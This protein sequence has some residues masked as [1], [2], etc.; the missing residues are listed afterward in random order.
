MRTVWNCTKLS[1]GVKAWPAVTCNALLPMSHLHHAVPTPL[2]T[3]IAKCHVAETTAGGWC[4]GWQHGRFSI[5]RF[6][7]DLSAHAVSILRRTTPTYMRSNRAMVL[8]MGLTQY[9]QKHM[10]GCCIPL[11]HHI[12]FF[13]KPIWLPAVGRLPAGKLP[14]E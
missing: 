6:C 13:W 4:F 11:V 5:K 2:S 7:P 12:H 9:I 8:V 14:F 1:A 10:V 3:Q